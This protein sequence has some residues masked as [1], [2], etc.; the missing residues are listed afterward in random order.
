[1][2]VEYEGDIGFIKSH[3]TVEIFN[4]YGQYVEIVLNKNIDP[5]ELLKALVEKIKIR[6]FEYA[7]SSLNEIFMDII[8]R[9]KNV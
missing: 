5:N 7:S 8:G 6:R 1:M 3:P 4:D 2:Q 9:E